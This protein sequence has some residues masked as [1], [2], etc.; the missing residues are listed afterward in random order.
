MTEPDNETSDEM[1][2]WSRFALSLV[3]VAIA[4]LVLFQP[5][6]SAPLWL[7]G[8]L[9]VVVGAA[10][11]AWVVSRHARNQ[12]SQH[13]KRGPGVLVALGTFFAL[14]T[15]TFVVSMVTVALFY[16]I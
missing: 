8:T 3:L 5:A 4:A 11:S 10:A 14:M 6:F 9:S 15:V 1:G 2:P 16:Y 13:A 12:S 7:R